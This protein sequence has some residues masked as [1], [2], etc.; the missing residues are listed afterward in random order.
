M[1]QAAKSVEQ[2]YSVAQVAALLGIRA[3][4]V[5]RRVKSGE[6]QPVLKLGHRTVRIPARAV[7]RWL[8]GAQV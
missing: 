4:T 3:S 7:N 6:I 2:H 1:S 8:A 5:W